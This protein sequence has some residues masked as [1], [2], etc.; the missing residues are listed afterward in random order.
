MMRVV[1]RNPTRGFDLT[2]D[3]KVEEGTTANHKG[4]RRL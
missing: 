4:V 3:R 1:D 2:Y